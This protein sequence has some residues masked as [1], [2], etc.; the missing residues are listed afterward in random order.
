MNIISHISRIIILPLLALCAAAAHALPLEHYASQS[1]LA[2]GQWVMVS[3]PESGLYRLTPSQLRQWGF[4]RPDSVR[5]YGY[6][7]ARIPD[8]LSAANYVDDLP[9]VQTLRQS[10]GSI[11]FYGVG[12][13][14]WTRSSTGYYHR[15]SNIYTTAGYYF[16]SDAPL[17]QPEP[18][19]PQQ[20]VAEAKADAATSFIDYAQ[21]EVDAVSP[22]EVGYVLVGESFKYQPSL[23]VSLPTPGAIADTPAWIEVSTVAKIYSNTS[24]SISLNG[25]PLDANAS[26]AFDATTNSS[27]VSASMSVARHSVEY[28]GEKAELTIT[29]RNASAALGAWLDYAALAYQRELKLP[30]EQY[31]HFTTDAPSALLAGAEATVLDVTDPARVTQLRTTRAGEATAW[32]SDFH[33]LRSYAAFTSAARLPQPAFVKHVA[34]QNLHAHQPVDM[35]IITVPEALAQ[36]Q[37]L[38][39]IHASAAQPLNVAVVNVNDIYNEFSSGSAD[40]SGLRKYLKMLYDRSQA[41]DTVAQLRYALLMGR[42]TVDNRHLTSAFTGSSAHSTIPVWMGGSAKTQF[43]DNDAFGTDDFIA[44]LEDGSGLRLGIDNLCVAVGRIPVQSTADAKNAVDKLEQYLNKPKATS[45]KNQYLFLTDTGDE[46]IHAQQSEQVINNLLSTPDNQAMAWRVYSDCYERT[47]GVR[48]G[49]REELYRLLNEGVL[50]W[51]YIGHANNHSMTKSGIVTFTDIN[52]MYLSRV[53][54][55]MAATCDFLRWDCSTLSGGEILYNERYGG[56]IAVI[57]ATR[58]VYISDNGRLSRAMG[59]QMARRD[60]DGNLPRLGDIYRGAKNNILNDAGAHMSNSNRLRYVLMGDPAMPMLTPSNI[61]TLDAIDG[62]P[63]TEDAQLTLQA[64]GRPVLSGSVR[65]PKGNILSDFNGLVDVTIYDAETSRA[66]MDDDPKAVVVYDQQGP[67][68]FAGVAKAQ[69][70]RFTIQASMPAEIDNNFRPATINM[71]A[72]S[73]SD[74]REAIG[75]NREVYV[76]GYDETQP[77]DTIP[78][79]IESMVLNHESFR[80]GD[81]VNESPMLIARVSDNVGLNLS[82]NGVGHQMSIAIDRLNTSTDVSLYFTPDSDF[83]GAGTI[84]Y[85]LDRLVDGAHTLRLKVW[86]TAGNSTSQDIDFFVMTGVAPTI[87]NVYTDTNPASTEANFYI[88]HNRPDQI[89]QVEITVYSLLGR[90]VWSG[91][92]QG[93]SDMFT[94]APVTWDLRDSSGQRVGRGIYLYSAKVTDQNGLEFDTAKQR[95]AVTAR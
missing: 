14:Q 63:L 5:V 82:T 9:P 19:I 44:M 54:I 89:L 61:V 11:V 58:P 32:S 93:V 72:H 50:W 12:S 45:W 39:R 95:I 92:A 17:G 46:G 65:D 57:S 8:E 80:P 68:I 30:A 27:Y 84:N 24:I 79:V 37:R 23:K 29:F 38:A 86:D 60:K 49:A 10:D 77:A 2:S 76:Y 56:T 70:G 75:V 6:G 81:T 35:V 42:A 28:S 43:S 73:A 13:E 15:E 74:P 48:T 3:V 4:A 88:S 67:K 33:G 55:L 66:T 53:P 41:S 87:Y 85:P 52:N 7:G 20:G 31:L 22:G 16:L 25:R 51:N 64:L 40:V 34:N 1:R 71:Y 18:Q 90:P 47:G 83:P 59:L 91:K 62:E 94:S 69:D 21:H 78:P 36:A 26:D